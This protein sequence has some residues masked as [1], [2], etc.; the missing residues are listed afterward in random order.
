MI[1]KPT[2]KPDTVK[3][4]GTEIAGISAKF[5]GR[6]SR[7]KPA[8]T[9]SAS[10]FIDTSSTPMTAAGNGVVGTTTASSTPRKLR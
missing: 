9:F 2:G 5:A 10:P 4:Q 8:R 1:C 6:F 3:P 7:S